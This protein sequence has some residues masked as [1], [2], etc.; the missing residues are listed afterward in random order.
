MT[1]LMTT[2]VPAQTERFRQIV[3]NEPDRLGRITEDA[4]AQGCLHEARGGR[5]GDTLVMVSL[6]FDRR[7]YPGDSRGWRGVEAVR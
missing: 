7:G 6:C 3:A 5:D 1:V 4:R 2:H